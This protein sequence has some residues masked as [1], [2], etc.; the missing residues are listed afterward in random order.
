MA[1]RKGCPLS[2]IACG[3]RRK[4]RGMQQRKAE[5]VMRVTSGGGNTEAAVGTSMGDPEIRL[6]FSTTSPVSQTGDSP[7]PCDCRPERLEVKESVMQVH[8]V[9][10]RGVP[11]PTRV[12]WERRN[13]A[14]DARFRKPGILRS[15]V[16]ATRNA[17]GREGSEC[18]A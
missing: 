3:P 11:T 9:P 4:V 14:A 10:W 7:D 12:A 1:V 15:L 8:E 2:V 6:T 5:T 16:D 18:D 17:Q 13:I